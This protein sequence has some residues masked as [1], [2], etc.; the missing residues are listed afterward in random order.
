[1]FSRVKTDFEAD[2]ERRIGEAELF[3]GYHVD[4]RPPLSPANSEEGDHQRRSEAGL[5][6]KIQVHI[7][8]NKD[9]TTSAVPIHSRQY[10]F[11]CWE[12]ES[13]E[14]SFHSSDVLY[15]TSTTLEESETAQESP[16]PKTPDLNQ[17]PH[18]WI[19]YDLDSKVM[20]G[21]TGANGAI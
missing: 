14:E 18:Y 17:Q 20:D 11:D 8:N 19:P 16:G 10:D 15:E 1:M 13:S 7:V 5:F 6:T 9:W 4:P 12:H 3:E 2:D 21:T